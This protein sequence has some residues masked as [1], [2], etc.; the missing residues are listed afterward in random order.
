[1]LRILAA[2]AVLAFTVYSVIDVVRTDGDTVR[3]LPK[4]AWLLV[5]LLFPLAGGLAWILIGRP[6][7]RTERGGGS[8]RGPLGPDDDPDFLRG[9]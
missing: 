8:P 6:Q 5:A 4:T 7:G 1:M 3:H 9:I 2:I